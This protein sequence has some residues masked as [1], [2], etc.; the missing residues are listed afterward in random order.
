METKYNKYTER[1]MIDMRYASYNRGMICG[2]YSAVGIV[3]FGILL[4]LSCFL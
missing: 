3:L 4:F 2:L 1:D